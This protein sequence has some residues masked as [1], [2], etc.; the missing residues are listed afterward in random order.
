MT[1]SEQM[2]EIPDFSNFQKEDCIGK[3]S[4]GTVYAISL[5]PKFEKKYALKHM[6]SLNLT[7]V[8]F[9]KNEFYSI[10]KYS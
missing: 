6:S 10:T 2:E 3:G 1:V 4:Y 7:Q 8:V 5:P 9:F